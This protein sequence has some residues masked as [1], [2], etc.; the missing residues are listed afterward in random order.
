MTRHVIRVEPDGTRVYS[1]YTRYKPMDDA[2]RT[3]VVRRPDDPRAVRFHGLWFLPL[4][5][6]PD[7]QRKK[8]VTR[9]D[10]D[11]YDHMPMPC[12]CDV[13]KRPAAAFWRRKWRKDN[14]LKPGV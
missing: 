6:L 14:G 7:D 12:R 8:I 10:S 2:D 9:P 11:A 13:C 3:N 1:N 5:L 4:K